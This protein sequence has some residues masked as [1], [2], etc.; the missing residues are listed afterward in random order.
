MKSI[1]LRCTLMLALGF[2]LP[3]M[4]AEEA[5]T[6]RDVE[7]TYSCLIEDI[8]AGTRHVDL[9]L[10]VASDTDGQT[11]S[12]TEIIKP[13]NGT[14]NTEEQY[15]NRIFHVRFEGPFAEVAKLEAEL[16]Y[17]IHRTAI[18]IQAAKEIQTG[19]EAAALTSYATYLSPNRLIPIDGR[20]DTIAKELGLN[21]EEP[22]ETGRKIY[23]YLIDEMEYNWLAEGAGTGDVL[24][25][26]DSKTGDCTDYNS[27]FL[28]LCR[29]QGI[30]ADHV[31]GFPIRSTKDKGRIPSF[32]CAAQ[33]YVK[34]VGW[35]PVDPSE[36]DKHPES[37][38]YLFG[39]Q[40]ASYMLFSHGRDID[41]VP[42]QQGP[43]L[44]LFI[45]PYVE[46]DGEIHEEMKYRVMFE[47]LK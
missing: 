24:W 9:W 29:S 46:V 7:I 5:A 1:I 12:K 39:S 38:D 44:N 21:P 31:F 32:H 18:D 10:P 40:S 4:A 22:M 16:R 27:L 25:A 36:A 42:K 41:L 17:E 19:G 43:P 34:G 6:Q 37:R 3:V 33:F 14:I 8:P 47:N 2:T 28:A 35:V 30:P 23:D 26:C 45:H 11:V 15:G 20:I 13:A